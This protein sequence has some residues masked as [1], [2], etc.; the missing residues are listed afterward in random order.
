MDRMG[1]KRKV[2]AAEVV[3]AVVFAVG[4]GL[5]VGAVDATAGVGAGLL[6][7]AVSGFAFVLAWEREHAQ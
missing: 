4:V 1:V 5:V 3:C 6:A 7:L 2:L